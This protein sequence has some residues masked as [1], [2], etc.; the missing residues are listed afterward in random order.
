MD[1]KPVRFIS[2][3]TEV[4]FDEEPTLR[5]KPG[6][7][8]HFTW[9]G[10]VWEITEILASWQDFSRRGDK[11][12]NMTPE[13]A[14]AA[15]RRGSWGVGKFYFQVVTASGRAFELYYDRAPKSASDRLG[16]WVLYREIK[17]IR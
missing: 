13:N 5:K 11:A 14:A 17:V 8:D 4:G 3:E 10:R 2:K 12:H 6:P 9:D 7:P 1:I 15:S 16:C